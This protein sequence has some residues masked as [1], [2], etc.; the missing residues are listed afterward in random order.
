MMVVL[1][2]RLP[3]ETLEIAFGGCRRLQSTMLLPGGFRY[4]TESPEL[5]MW[6]RIICLRYKA[7][8]NCYGCLPP[9]HVSMMSSR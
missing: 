4:F 3:L 1:R 2:L 8:F 5:N 9:K 7:P 6:V